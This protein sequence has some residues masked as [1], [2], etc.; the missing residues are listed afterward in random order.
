MY[1]LIVNLNLNLESD[2]NPWRLSF[3]FKRALQA[4]CWAAMYMLCLARGDAQATAGLRRPWRMGPCDAAALCTNCRDGHLTAMAGVEQ[5][6]SE[7]FSRRLPGAGE[8]AG[9]LAAGPWVA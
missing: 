9:G 3:S 1:A 4:R 5:N 8:R 6:T 7:R 2:P